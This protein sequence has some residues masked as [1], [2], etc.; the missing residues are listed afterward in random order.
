MRKIFEGNIG[1]LL[2]AGA[3]AAIALT[4]CAS[5]S[6]SSSASEDTSSSAEVTTIRVHTTDGPSPYLYLDEDG[7]PDGFDIAVFKEAISRLP[8]YEAEYIVADDGLTGVLSG[9][10]D[11]TVGN[12]VY[13]EE[14]GESYYFSYPYK[15]T[16]KAFVQREDDEPLTDLHDA[17]A[18]GY[19]VIVG[20]TGGDTTAMEKWNEEHPDEQIEIIYTDATVVV[21]YQNV[22]DG[23]ADFT[24]D[25]GPM[26]SAYFNAYDFEGLQKVTLSDDALT[27]ILETVDTYFLYAK[28]EAGLK[29]RDD[30]N[31]AIK[32]MYEDGTLDELSIEYF[33]YTTTPDAS[34]FETTIN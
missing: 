5:D 20:A 29:L 30:I 24:L 12:W 14:R 3:A 16:D 27:D 11:V 7:N 2:I 1:T 31:V 19:K 15:V 23:I 17:A 26:I 22:A 34:G 4:G 10:Y 21:R 25:D 6:E 28:D 9:I 13:N 8:Q 32:E 33:G 18:R